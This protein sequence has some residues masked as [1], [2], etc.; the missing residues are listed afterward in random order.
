MSLTN[1]TEGRLSLLPDVVTDPER[2]FA[3]YQG[4]WVLVVVGSVYWLFD[5]NHRVGDWQASDPMSLHTHG[6]AIVGI[7][8]SLVVDRNQVKLVRRL[9]SVGV[10]DVEEEKFPTISRRLSS[11]SFVC[12]IILSCF[13]ILGLI[14]VLRAVGKLGLTE[15]AAAAL[16]TYSAVGLRIGRMLATSLTVLVIFSEIKSFRLMV[17][18]PDSSGGV[19]FIGRFHVK[20]GGIFLLPVGL[21]LYW[22]WTLNQWS[23]TYDSWRPYLI[24]LLITFIIF[25]AFIVLFPLRIYRSHIVS[26]KGKYLDPIMNRTL[27]E[28]NQ[29]TEC[30][31]DPEKFVNQR[32]QKTEYLASMASLP[33][34]P[35][36]SA[37]V[38]NI[39][40]FLIIPLLVTLITV[41]MAN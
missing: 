24:A 26:W 25:S 5:Y 30:Q 39:W 7:I 41:A 6:A 38:R 10:I 11:I 18:H 28:I 9:Q 3:V 34:W 19:D 31:V 22:L 1:S 13:F 12:Q 21:L 16:V 17:D 23:Q 40:I 32:K 29:L 8:C 2:R 15:G 20:Q 36:S 35:L 27:S 37:T 4:I 14:V 33:D